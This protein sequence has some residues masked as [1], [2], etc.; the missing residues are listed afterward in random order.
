MNKICYRNLRKIAEDLPVYSK[1]AIKNYKAEQAYPG[2]LN[3]DP[4]Y[5]KLLDNA[6]KAYTAAEKKLEDATRFGRLINPEYMQR[7]REEYMMRERLYTQAYNA[8]Y[9]TA[10]RPFEDPQLP[11]TPEQAAG[12][13]QKN[14][15]WS[16]VGDAAKTI[17]R[18]LVRAGSEFI[19]DLGSILDPRTW[20]EHRKAFKAGFDRKPMPDTPHITSWNNAS[21]NIISTVNDNVFPY[22]N[23]HNADVAKTWIETPQSIVWNI[24]GSTALARASKAAKASSALNKAQRAKQFAKRGLFSTAAF[25]DDVGGVHRGV[26]PTLSYLLGASM[27]NPEAPASAFGE[28]PTSRTT[29][30]H[31]AVNPTAM[32]FGANS[33][34]SW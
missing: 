14:I 32:Q 28:S 6:E 16:D 15:S 2:S 22:S 19:G 10:T 7:L 34:L 25:G 24:G 4:G 21:D 11:L 23:P 12:A 30:A 13:K 5:V 8:L 31:G 27:T 1:A 18:S 33:D 17:P 9:A 20:P 29:A 26:V 3:V